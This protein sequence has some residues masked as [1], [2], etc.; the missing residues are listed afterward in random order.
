MRDEH[1]GGNESQ[2]AE[3]RVEYDR[4]EHVRGHHHLASDGVWCE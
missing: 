1:A 3:V 4:D 2:D